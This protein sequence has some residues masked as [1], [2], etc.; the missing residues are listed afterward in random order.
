MIKKLDQKFLVRQAIVHTNTLSRNNKERIS[1]ALP[2][3]ENM[4][5]KMNNR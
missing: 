5:D 2:K 1:Q 4:K 3:Y